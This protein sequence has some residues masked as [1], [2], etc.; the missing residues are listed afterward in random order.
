MTKILLVV[1]FKKLNIKI[2]KLEEILNESRMK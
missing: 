1:Y 2:F